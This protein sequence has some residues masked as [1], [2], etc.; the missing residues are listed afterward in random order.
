MARRTFAVS[1]FWEFGLGAGVKSGTR[2]VKNGSADEEDEVEEVVGTE[3]DAKPEF[4]AEPE[5]AAA[6]TAEVEEA[7][8]GLEEEE[9]TALSTRTPIVRLGRATFISE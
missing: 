6:A 1:F 2:L 8:R 7:D 5:A 9:E 3:P 4:E